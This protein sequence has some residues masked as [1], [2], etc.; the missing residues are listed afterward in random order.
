MPRFQANTPRPRHDWDAAWI[1]YVAGATLEEVSEASG[2]PY[3]ELIQYSAKKAWQANRAATHKLAN[4]NVTDK[5]ATRIQRLRVK[6]QHFV[7]DQVE[8]V[9]GHIEQTEVGMID[10]DDPEGKRRMTMGKKI[11]L[12]QK[13]D[14]L[15]RPTLGLDE[16]EEKVDPVAAG[17]AMLVAMGKG[18]QQGTL[19][20]NDPKQIED[21]TIEGEY[22]ELNPEP[23]NEID[24]N[25]NPNPQP[26]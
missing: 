23:E 8:E 4:K 14:T 11:D 9:A 6:H 17:F 18:M 22:Q 10:P 13:L 16:K 15:V 21:R 1:L 5:L 3:G 7:L 19:R 2:I 24:P 20:A 25:S 26:E 12:V